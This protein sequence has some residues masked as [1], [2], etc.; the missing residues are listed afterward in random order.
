MLIFLT[1]YLE[2]PHN[3]CIKSI[4]IFVIGPSNL[5]DYLWLDDIINLSKFVRPAGCLI[6]NKMIDTLLKG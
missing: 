2:V 3:Q 1:D 6:L 4:F 5:R